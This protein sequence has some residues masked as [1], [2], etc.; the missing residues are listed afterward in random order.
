MQITEIETFVVANPPPSFG[1]R[2]FLFVRLT[3]D[4]GVTGLGEAYV[5]TF[6]PHLVGHSPFAVDT[7]H[8]TPVEDVPGPAT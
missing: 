4:G 3:T 7:L 6:D 1:G 8:L 2:Y 5:S